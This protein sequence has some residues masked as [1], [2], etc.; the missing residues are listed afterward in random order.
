MCHVDEVVSTTK[1]FTD[2]FLDDPQIRI[3]A[4]S[5]LGRRTITLNYVESEATV[6]C[7]GL[8]RNAMRSGRDGHRGQR[9][10]G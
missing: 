3:I 1:S 5:H 4:A 10:K 9:S 2:L 6:K 8:H 7:I